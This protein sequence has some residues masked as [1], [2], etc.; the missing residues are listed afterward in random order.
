MRHQTRLQEGAAAGLRH[1]SPCFWGTCCC[2]GSHFAWHQV[3]GK[4]VNLVTTEYCGCCGSGGGCSFPFATSSPH[5]SF[6]IVV[7]PA[8]FFLCLAGLQTVDCS[9][10]LLG[11]RFGAKV[12]FAREACQKKVRS[13]AL[14]LSPSPCATWPK[15]RTSK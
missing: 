8:L 4:E 10:L 12:S 11:A 15:E 9:C 7:S 1:C 13:A 5:C 2:R 14:P 3:K 6:P